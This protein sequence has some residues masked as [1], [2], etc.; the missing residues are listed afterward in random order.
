MEKELERLVVKKVIELVQFAEWA[1]P[2]VPVFKKNGSVRICRDYKVTVN[3]CAKTDKY[4]LPPIEDIFAALS[5]GQTFTKLD[6]ANA[7]LQLPLED[8]SRN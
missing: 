1:A 2:I 3:R 4:P 7:F 8:K 5:G 6:L